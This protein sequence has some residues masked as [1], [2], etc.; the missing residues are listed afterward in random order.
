MF[1]AIP[2]LLFA[3]VP[4]RSTTGA[5]LLLSAPLTLIVAIAQVGINLKQLQPTTYGAVLAVA[6]LSSVIFPLLCR[7]MLRH[8]MNPARRG[9]IRQV[10]RSARVRISLGLNS[11]AI[12][13]LDAGSKRPA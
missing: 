1:A 10:I 13:P 3:G 8:E 2:L 6:I 11:P 7:P 5:V 12:P 4:W 9:R